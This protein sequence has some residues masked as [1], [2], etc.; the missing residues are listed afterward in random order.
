M[1]KKPIVAFKMPASFAWVPVIGRKGKSE[2]QTNALSI[3]SSGAVQRSCW[4]L[5]V[6]DRAI[7]VGPSDFL[8]PSTPVTPTEKIH[9]SDIFTV[10]PNYI[11]IG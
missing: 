6:R 7:R 2:K 3:T 4:R 8:F 10:L 5:A 1:S 9:L 11:P